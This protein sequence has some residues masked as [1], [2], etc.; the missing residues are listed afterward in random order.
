M[1]LIDKI[2][3]HKIIYTWEINIMSKN[4]QDFVFFQIIINSKQSELLK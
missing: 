2:P 4:S 3:K 1:L